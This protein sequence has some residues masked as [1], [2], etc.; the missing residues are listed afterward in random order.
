MYHTVAEEMKL[1]INTGKFNV[2]QGVMFVTRI[3]KQ[4]EASAG[5]VFVP[6][7]DDFPPPHQQ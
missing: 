5:S 2:G 4:E 3:L 7:R 1:F 6:S